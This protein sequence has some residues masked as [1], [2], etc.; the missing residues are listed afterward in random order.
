VP[1][2]FAH[3]A[4]ALPLL[5][6]LG[7]Y[8]SV[9]ALCIGSIAPDL[10]FIVPIGLARWQ[11]HSLGALFWFC[12]PAGLLVYL[13][14]HA[15]L[16]RPLIDLLPA[17]IAARVAGAQPG[18]GAAAVRQPRGE[19]LVPALE[20][21]PVPT[22]EP[23]LV[24]LLCGALTHLVWDAFTHPGTLVVEA[25]PVLQVN[26]ATTGGY[27][28]H[29]YKVLQHASSVLGLALLACWTWSWLRRA[30]AASGPVPRLL[31]P[32]LRLGAWAALLGTPLS[33]GM[34]AGWR[35]QDSIANLVDLQD[36]AT[37]FIFTALPVTAL[38]LA[39]YSVLWTWQARQQRLR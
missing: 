27:R 24:S 31:S 19:V 33:A 30:P 11:T 38:A 1:F 35:Y 28:W 16:K 8:G 5:R 3:P 25:L 32:A 20:P 22:P 6:P 36:F 14:F 7:R 18:P 15:L 9:S 34:I 10:A 21:V 23:V 37:A 12:L 4:A 17:A 13:L 39:L 2:T 29:A 26:L